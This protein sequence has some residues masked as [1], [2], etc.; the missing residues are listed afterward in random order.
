MT[1]SISSDDVSR[2]NREARVKQVMDQLRKNAPQCF[3]S[4]EETEP[5]MF[6]EAMKK[7][8]LSKLGLKE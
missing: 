1:K 4:E 7:W 2:Q 6:S 5:T 3:V 8:A